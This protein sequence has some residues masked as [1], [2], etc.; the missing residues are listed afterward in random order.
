MQK[1][2]E[3][4]VLEGITKR[5]VLGQV[6]LLGDDCCHPKPGMLGNGSPREV[7]RSAASHPISW[8]E[9]SCRILLWLSR[10]DWIKSQ[11]CWCHGF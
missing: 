1:T 10:R 4:E 8:M 5:L 6:S 2:T 11:P 3:K 9:W 7:G